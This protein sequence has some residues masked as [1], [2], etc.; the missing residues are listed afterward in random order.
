MLTQ[1]KQEIIIKLK[2][3]ITSIITNNLV[4]VFYNVLISHIVLDVWFHLVSKSLNGKTDLYCIFH[5]G[6][7]AY[8][9]VTTGICRHVSNVMF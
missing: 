2:Y 3:F 9:I 8:E 1:I 6:A 5:C 7:F 4:K